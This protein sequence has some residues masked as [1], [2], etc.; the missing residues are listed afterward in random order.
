MRKS[1]VCSAAAVAALWLA[2]L[3]AARGSAAAPN[4]EAPLA[5]G[6]QQLYRLDLL[7]Q[8]RQSVRVGCVSSYDRTGGNDDGFSG[9]YSF[10][11]KEG[12][13]LVIADLKGPGAIYRIWTPTPTDDPIEF[14]FDGESRPR[15][16][17]KYRELF[18]GDHPPFVRPV[19]GHGLGGLW[20]YL[21]LPYRKSCKV[22]IRGPRVQFYQINYATYP[23][24]TAL[25]TFDPAAPGLSAEMERASRLLRSTGEDLTPFTAPE[26]RVRTD[27]FSAHLAPGASVRLW[28]TRRG[29]RVVGLRL[30]PADQLAGK[31]RDILLRITWDGDRQPAVL[32]PAGDFFGASWGDP[33]MRSLLVG[34]AANRDYV[35]FPMPFDRS[36]RIELVS[37]RAGGAPVEVS[38]EVLYTSTARRRD[39]GRFYAVWRRENPTT[40][41]QPFTWLETSGRGHVVGVTLQAQGMEPG[42]TPFFEGDDQVT[43]DGELAIHGTGSEDSFNGGW[44]DVPD[45]WEG[46]G[47]LPLSGCLDYQRPLAR[48]GGFRLFLSDAYAFSRSIHLAIEHA[49]ERNAIPTDYTGVTYLYAENHPAMA[50]TVLPAAQRAVHDPERLVYTPGWY[51]P[52]HSFSVQNA[53]VTRRE[54]RIGKDPVRFLSMRAH[55]EDVFGLHHVAVTCDVP[56]EGRYRVSADLLEG[57]EGGIVQLY[58]QEQ[59]A[60]AAVD[61]YA[62]ERG[63]RRS[64]ALGVLDL[65]AGR[66]PVFFKLVGKN[67]GARAMGLDLV[68]VTLEKSEPR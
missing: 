7:P 41:G 65:K 30:G 35:Y 43:I 36:A 66:N 31:A 17:M 51:V 9:R 45:R 37:E 39:E 11:R 28:E 13:G 42:V 60:G 29:G 67:A 19:V 34:T 57:P 25:E 2:L 47:S 33:A 16:R 56:A 46:R 55:D 59:P 64:I 8:F 27:R 23:E 58:Q 32:C 1:A 3:G 20:S 15:V 54:E 10:I 49:P 52:L 18:G 48:S 40:I 24:G 38:G 4:P 14:Y 21:P 26:Q 22:I 50:G 63:R 61:L 44:Y 12:D 53:V 6:L 62:P 5:V 68:T